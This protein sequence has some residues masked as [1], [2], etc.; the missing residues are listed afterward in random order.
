[1]SM[2]VRTRRATPQPPQT[3]VPSA[4]RSGFGITR[5]VLPFPDTRPRARVPGRDNIPGSVWPSRPRT[6]G[7]TVTVPRSG[8]S[9]DSHAPACCSSS[10]VSR[11][12]WGD[13]L[14]G[15]SSGEPSW[16]PH[17]PPY[18]KRSV[19]TSHCG[20]RFPVRPYNTQ[21]GHKAARRRPKRLAP[22]VKNPRFRAR[23][24]VTSL[25]APGRSHRA[26]Y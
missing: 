19:T 24:A 14:L 3:R 18:S 11:F 4:R 15:F 5:T 9:R 20:A 8:S 6:A 26:P 7:N 2:S 12:T 21:C 13:R 22:I 23:N 25:Q 1:M 10:S 17:C 16:P